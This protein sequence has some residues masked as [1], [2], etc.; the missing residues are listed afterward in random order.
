MTG[1]KKCGILP[2]EVYALSRIKDYQGAMER[3]LDSLQREGR[4]PALLLQDCCAPCGS[5]V[6][7]LLA[8]FFRVTVLFYNPNIYPA[9]EYEKRLGEVRKLLRRME[10][11]I[12]VELMP[13]GYDDAAFSACAAGLEDEPE[14]GAR[15]EKCFRLRLETTARLAGEHGFEYFSTTLTVSPHKDPDLINGIGAELER[16]YGVR[17]L[18]AEFK[19]RDGYRQ[20]IELSRKYDLYRQDYCGCAFSLRDRQLQK[21]AKKEKEDT[22]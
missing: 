17:F 19:K 6:I 10:T 4:T 16:E 22:R 7:G 5:Y 14:G 2:Q 1:V 20:S 18:E 11:P 15:C 8:Q 12:P 13:C 9:G 21:A 3:E